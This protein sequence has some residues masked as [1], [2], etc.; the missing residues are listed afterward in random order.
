[1]ENKRNI[2]PGLVLGALIVV[3]GFLLSAGA[4]YPGFMSA[5]SL[6]QYDQSLTLRLSDWHPPLMSALWSLLNQ[7]A[8]GPEGMLYFQLALLWA[9]LAVWC[10]QYRTRPLAWLI[11]LIGVMPWVLN[12]AGVLWKDIGMAYALLLM[13]GIA[14]GPVTGARLAAAFVLFFYAVNL[15]HNAIAA[16]V[17]VLV[18]VMARWRPALSPL[19]LA[20]AAIAALAVT[21]ALGNVINYRLLDAERTKPLNFIMIDDLSYLSLKEQRSL[22]PGVKIEHIQACALRT[23]SETR[24]LAR[25]VC[26][27]AF[28][29]PGSLLSADLKPLWLS[30]IARNKLD[31]LEFRVNAFGFLLRSPETEPFYYWHD[32]LVANKYGLKAQ[33]SDVSAQVEAVIQDSAEAVPFL[34]KPYWWLGAATVLLAGSIL[35][36]ASRTV[37]T[38]Q[39][40]LISA[41]LYTLGYVPVT[42]LADL[43][44]VYW[45]MLATTLAAL[46]LVVDRPSWRA[47]SHLL[48]AALALGAGAVVV[49]CMNAQRLAPIDM[50]LVHLASLAGPNTVATPPEAMQHLVA[51]QDSYTITGPKPQIDVAFAHGGI[52]PASAR[53]L[54]FDF[55]CLDSKV[56]PTLRL[57]WWGDLQ[58]GPRDDQATFVH[59]RHGQILVPVQDL[60]NWNSTARI[61]RLRFNMFEFGSCTKMSLRN[62][63]VYR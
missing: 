61:T 59:G 48:K 27:Q 50:D 60:P 25:D 33:P 16:A 18:L 58:L 45:S 14:A 49:L 44:Y 43:R 22:L 17:P 4:F 46:L 8:R 30:A 47:T 57:L 41:I 42:P 62:V 5:D 3:A 1:M 10:W 7:V 11:P 36:R 56:E 20:G 55:S 15:R 35:L 39:A 12:F 52:V 28:V 32:G 21:L 53:Y 9:G 13:T 29:E 2:R 24:T 6:M 40:L 19:R 63:T 37:R 34:F 51:A 38:V 23:I 26:L 54:G 31:Y